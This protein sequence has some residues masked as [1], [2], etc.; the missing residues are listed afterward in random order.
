M[1]WA[2]FKYYVNLKPSTAFQIKD[3]VDVLTRD[4]GD[5]E[6]YGLREI[7][8]SEAPWIDV[9]NGLPEGAK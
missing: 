8:H 6:P 7:S 1:Y 5:M 4:Y 9:R 3:Y 2:I